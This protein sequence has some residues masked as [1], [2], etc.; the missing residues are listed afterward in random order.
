MRAVG[1]FGNTVCVVAKCSRIACDGAGG[2]EDDA[3]PHEYR[4]IPIARIEAHDRRVCLRDCL[5]DEVRLLHHDSLFLRDNACGCL[6]GGSDRL[7]GV[8]DDAID[9][10]RHNGRRLVHERHSNDA[11]RDGRYERDKQG[12]EDD[13]GF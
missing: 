10:L 5:R 8:L 6:P 3:E 7:H 13:L 1:K 4:S 12:E 9:R 2:I 11:G